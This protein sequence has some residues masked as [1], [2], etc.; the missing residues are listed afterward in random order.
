MINPSD[1][2]CWIYKDPIQDHK[3]SHGNTLVSTIM[4]LEN[5][6]K[7]FTSLLDRRYILHEIWLI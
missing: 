7:A 1:P 6:K 5:L 2:R 3:K 4:V